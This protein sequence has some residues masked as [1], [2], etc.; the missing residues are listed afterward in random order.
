MP[1]VFLDVDGALRDLVAGVLGR[2]LAETGEEISPEAILNYDFS[3][4]FSLE[5]AAAIYS[6]PGFDCP[7]YPGAEKFVGRL[8]AVVPDS[9]RNLH[10]VS[11][12]SPKPGGFQELANK[13]AWLA[14]FFKKI[15]A[16]DP[17]HFTTDKTLLFR[18]G[19]IVI[20][21]NPRILEAALKAGAHPVCIA[22]PWNTPESTPP[23]RG[24]RYSFESAVVRI[25]V[26][27]G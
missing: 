5:K 8:S 18:E 4:V 13:M 3:P 16:P 21:D 1:R 17:F 20:D 27:S 10:I 9:I 19:D 2:R 15:H 7:A 11:E 12:F 6:K 26:L 22:R 25:G 24:L 23:W 14:G